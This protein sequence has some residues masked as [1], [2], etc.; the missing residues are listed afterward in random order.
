[1]PRNCAVVSTDNERLSRVLSPG[2]GQTRLQGAL[3]NKCRPSEPFVD[4]DKGAA[5]LDV[6]GPKSVGVGGHLGPDIPLDI[7]KIAGPPANSSGARGRHA[8][9]WIVSL[10]FGALREVG[11]ELVDCY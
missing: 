7:C 6:A 11:C 2:T 8:G 5:C 1:V 9:A 10:A 3:G 4:R